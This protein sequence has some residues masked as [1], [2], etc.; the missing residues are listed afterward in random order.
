MALVHYPV[1]NKNSETI[2]SAV[3]NLDLH[4][5]ARAG[6]TYGINRFYVVTP[7][8][9]QQNLVREIVDHWLT[10]YGARYNPKRKEALEII[11]ICADLES[12]YEQLVVKWQTRPTVIATSARAGDNQVSYDLVRQRIKAGERFLLLFGTG[13]GLTPEV[14]AGVDRVLPPI[15]GGGDYNH[16]SVR[17]AASVVLDRLMGER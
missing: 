7:Y 3:T 6:R 5:I 17:S 9:D 8:Q 2:G 4:D 15:Y 11:R 13:W 12:L 16:L 1:S 14:M 10:G